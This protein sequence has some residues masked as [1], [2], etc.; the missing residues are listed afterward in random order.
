MRR[1]TAAAAFL[2]GRQEQGQRS[3]GS[4][5]HRGG[6]QQFFSEHVFSVFSRGVG[7]ECGGEI[8][9]F[10]FIALSF[11]MFLSLS[12]SR[13]T[14]QTKRVRHKSFEIL[15]ITSGKTKHLGS[16]H[17]RGDPLN[18]GQRGSASR[19]GESLAIRPPDCVSQNEAQRRAAISTFAISRE[20]DPLPV[21]SLHLQ[22]RLRRR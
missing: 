5:V 4:G 10:Y 20:T 19:S 17:F 13:R 15:P 8:A 1:R 2:E 12:N 22:R 6:A 14:R 7:M 18:S 16:T 11:E 21:F 9:I 3:L